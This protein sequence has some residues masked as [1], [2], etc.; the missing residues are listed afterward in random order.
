LVGP[1]DAQVVLP[2]VNR[3]S[4]FPHAQDVFVVGC[5][6]GDFLDALAVILL[7]DDGNQI[8]LR[9]PRDNFTCEG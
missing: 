3:I 8:I 6:S 9:S 2:L 7:D 4:Y 1:D 5:Q